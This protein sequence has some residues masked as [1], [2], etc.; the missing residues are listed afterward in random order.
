VFVTDIDGAREALR[1]GR[2]QELLGLAES[3]WL[4]VK[5]GIYRLD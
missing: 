4:D 3:G 5:R 1:A 2:P